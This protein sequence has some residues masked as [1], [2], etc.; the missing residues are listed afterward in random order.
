[1]HLILWEQDPV[2]LFWSKTTILICKPE[3]SPR[4]CLKI[5]SPKTYQDSG[6]QKRGKLH[7][8]CK[9]LAKTVYSQEDHHV[10]QTPWYQMPWLPS[11]WEMP[12]ISLMWTGFLSQDHGDQDS[13]WLGLGVCWKVILDAE[14]VGLIIDFNIFHTHM[15]I[16]YSC[17]YM[18]YGF[19]NISIWS[20]LLVQA[21]NLDFVGIIPS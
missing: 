14:N 1:M 2:V 10:Y 13:I 3:K 9:T 4:P 20:F 8:L 17:H 19:S 16:I 12:I 6:Q 7:K 11:H 5:F 15:Y 18:S 21:P